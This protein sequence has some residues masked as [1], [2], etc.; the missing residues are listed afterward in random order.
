MKQRGKTKAVSRLAATHAS[1]LGAEQGGDV[2]RQTDTATR[3]A[4]RAALEAARS[5]ETG[6]T[7]PAA[8]AAIATEA[9]FWTV[10]DGTVFAGVWSRSLVS[11]HLV[12]HPLAISSVVN[13]SA[14]IEARGLRVVC[15]DEDPQ[16]IFNLRRLAGA[17]AVFWCEIYDETF[18][19]QNV[20][21]YLDYGDGFSERHRLQLVASGN[22]W[23]TELMNTEGLCSVRLDPSDGMCDFVLIK[24][25]ITGIIAS[26]EPGALTGGGVA[27]ECFEGFEWDQATG[28]AVSTHNDPQLH[29]RIP[30]REP[31]HATPLLRL[32]MRGQFGR[33]PEKAPKIYLGASEEFAADFQMTAENTYSL[34]LV[35]AN[36]LETIRVDP[37][38][39]RVAFRISDIR[40][41]EMTEQET[42]RL[43]ATSTPKALA[44]VSHWSEHVA[45]SE[46]IRAN[47]RHASLRTTTYAASGWTPALGEPPS[48]QLWIRRNDITRARLELQ[49]RYQN[50]MLWRPLISLIVPVYKVSAGIFMALVQ[51]VLEQSYTN[52]ELCVCLAYHEDPE[53][54]AAVSTAAGLSQRIKCKILTKNGGISRNSNAALDIATGDYLAL[55]DHDDLISPDA[56]YEIAQ[57]IVANPGVDLV[58]SDKDM[59]DEAGRIRQSPLFKPTWSPEIMLSANYL[60]HFNAMRRERVLEIGAWDPISDGAQDWDIFLRVIGKLD[61]VVHIPKV[62]YHWRITSTSVASCGLATKPYAAKAQLVSVQGMLDRRGWA[63]ATP[64]FAENGVLLV[65]WRKDPDLRTH[66]IMLGGSPDDNSQWSPAGEFCTVSRLTGRFVDV[67]TLNQT[68]EDVAADVVVIFPMWL[69][70]LS[71]WVHEMVGPLSNQEIG[72]VT[73][74]LLGQKNEI[75]DCGWVVDQSVLKAVFKNL[76]RH[77]YT[78]IG[79]VDWFRNVTAV[80]FSGMSFRRSDWKKVGGFVDVYRPDLEFSQRLT[81]QLKTR[82]LFNPFAEAWLSQ[83]EDLEDVV[84]FSKA[85]EPPLAP[86]LPTCFSPNLCITAAGEIALLQVSDSRTV[87]MPH[88]YDAEAGYVANTFDYTRQ[89]IAASLSHLSLVKRDGAGKHVVWFVPNF[90][91]P[92]YGGI[93]TILRAAEFMRHV[94]DVK[95][96]VV[97]VSCNST[98]GLRTAIGKA[99]PLLAQQATILSLMENENVNSLGIGAAD[100]AFCTLWTTAYPLL[101]LR[102]VAQKIYFVQDYEPLF[103][104]A[105]TTSSL[106]EATYRFGF[107]GICNTAPL[108]ELY[109]S[110]GGTADYF[111]PAIDPTIFH[112]RG[113]EEQSPDRPV[114]IF[115]Y[116]RPGHPRNCFDIIA[117]GLKRVKDRLKDKALIFTAGADWA[118]DN[119]GL[120][121]VVEH[122]GLL[123]YGMTGQLYRA[124][125]IGVVAMATRHP[126]Y[127]PFELMASGAVVC[128][129]FSRYTD[130]LLQHGNNA[131]L[132]DLSLSSVSQTI[133]RAALDVQAR[134]RITGAAQA[135]IR[136]EYS[137]WDRT[138][139]RIYALVFPVSRAETTLQGDGAP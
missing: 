75:L 34:I 63:G 113:R 45:R 56:L 116:A 87:V 122:L 39:E 76:S 16:L 54:S 10:N 97:G 135:L 47:V 136:A 129:N 117:A 80:S 123:D 88:N 61:K 4:R 69:E 27:V 31:A 118:P 24:A 62:L 71:D 52:W 130:W 22:R 1:Q 37:V 68:I 43:S 49:R 109:R 57:A 48:Y 44:E 66:V 126:S 23:S 111:K 125:D 132:F 84:G 78:M 64:S 104:P 73:G 14:D 77:H 99:F 65:T 59:I 128:T 17:P 50:E 3:A 40:L 107:Y 32:E 2:Q 98:A 133:L 21:V 36:L 41:R 138:C 124:C 92:F 114:T 81:L 103:Y 53:L 79:S 119:Y 67:A 85:E 72:A 6:A 51:S 30:A 115:N 96:T 89:D 86:E 82:N 9:F 28:F 35:Y 29:L 33:E 70:P 112:A 74:K 7:T 120:G 13:C 8:G 60:T 110:H 93:M 139:A 137:D 127:L 15:H 46:T 106:V 94:H 26:L 134:K 58:Y 95:I 108:A 121:G 105:G 25:G 91:M 18:E 19:L 83:G 20:S 90:S 55:L 5:V 38:D 12:D 100:A 42:A 11:D 101:K 131:I 102:N